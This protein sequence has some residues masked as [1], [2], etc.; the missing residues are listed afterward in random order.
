MPLQ[1]ITFPVG[2][3][4]CNCTILADPVARTAYVVDPGAEIGMV[5]RHL[6]ELGCKLEGIL[7]THA[8]IDH[9]GGAAELKR[10]TGAP[11]WLHPRDLGLYGLLDWQANLLGLPGAES[12]TIDAA[13]DR[14][15]RLG[16]IQI[17]ETPGHSEGSVSLYVP[18]E[19][20]LLA[21]DT[22]FAGSIGRTDLPG[23]DFSTLLR[24]IHSA[25]LTLP[26]ATIVVPGHGPETTI[27][28]ER[29]SNPFLKS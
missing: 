28:R 11:V 22:L 18:E 5:L 12:T 1:R 13:L 25:L 21:G 19:N 14:N 17:L 4:A 26:D 3:L 9:I 2:P 8:H 10:R 7:I 24:S 29:R 20:L 23:G 6:A 15:A 16:P 27:A